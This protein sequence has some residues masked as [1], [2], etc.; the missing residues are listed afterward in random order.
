MR[1]QSH[2]HPKPRSDANAPYH[3]NLLQ[4]QTTAGAQQHADTI[5]PT[6][7]LD[8]ASQPLM[9]T[10]LSCILHASVQ[11]ALHPGCYQSTMDE[12]FD[13]NN[14]P[15]VKFPNSV[16]TTAILKGEQAEE[17]RASIHEGLVVS[18]GRPTSQQTPR[19]RSISPLSHT[20]HSLTIDED[21]A[22]EG[23]V[24]MEMGEI[25]T[26]TK[27]PL[28]LGASFN[29]KNI[30]DDD[31]IF[32]SPGNEPKSKRP[33][34]EKDSKTKFRPIY[35]PTPT[36]SPVR[37]DRSD[38]V[39]QTSPIASEMK[40]LINLGITIHYPTEWQRGDSPYH[41]EVILEAMKEEN[42]TCRNGQIIPLSNKSKNQ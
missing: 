26:T 4:D 39:T 17:I 6:L 41:H 7:G 28:S 5:N 23:A 38:S 13:L 35:T 10:I 19:Q 33:T 31:N 12:V 37:R 20:S 1:S 14:I 36:S 34:K 40:T 30:E 2:Q 15:R 8:I 9:T 29:N 21:F 16:S 27:R 3:P 24:G 32:L 22:D 25:E 11:N 42:K 18:S